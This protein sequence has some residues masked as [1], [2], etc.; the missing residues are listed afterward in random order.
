MST[1]DDRYWREGTDLF[2]FFL[3][4]NCGEKITRLGEGGVVPDADL[5]RIQANVDGSIA[6]F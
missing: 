3:M 1:F 2:L 5:R 4:R 6:L